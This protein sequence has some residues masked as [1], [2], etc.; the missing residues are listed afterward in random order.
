MKLMIFS[1]FDS[2]AAYFSNPF[3][4]Q[5]EEE[6][7]RIASDAVS[8]TGN[9]NNLWARHPE[10]F[11]LFKL[12]HFDSLTGEIERQL[13]ESLATLS[14]LRNIK[15]TEQLELFKQEAVN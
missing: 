9:P 3:F 1:I 6:A 14:S 13:P 11:S 8:E 5:R 10:D 2:K 12:G 4:C 7:L 15:S